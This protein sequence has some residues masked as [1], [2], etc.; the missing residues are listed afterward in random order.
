MA[1]LSKH[2]YAPQYE[3]NPQH[4]EDRMA[5]LFKRVIQKDEQK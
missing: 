5:L 4:T 3:K 1:V 2:G